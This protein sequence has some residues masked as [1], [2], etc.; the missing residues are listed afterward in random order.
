MMS[1]I[2][3]LSSIDL[4]SILRKFCAEKYQRNEKVCLSS[5]TTK[6]FS[7]MLC[8]FS[9]EHTILTLH[10]KSD[11]NDSRADFFVKN[12]VKSLKE[13]AKESRFF[14]K[15]FGV[16]SE[17]L[18]KLKPLVTIKW[19]PNCYL[20]KENVLV[21]ENLQDAG[22]EM[23]TNNNGL[24][25]VHHHLVAVSLL[26]AMHASSIV[27]E[28]E[29]NKIESEEW[30]HFLDENSYPSDPNAV[31]NMTLK[32]TVETL[33]E[34]LTRLPKYKDKCKEILPK[35]RKL[36]HQITDFVRPSQHYRNVFCHGDLWA[37][38]ILFKYATFSNGIDMND[39][40]PVAAVFVDFQLS[41]YAPPALDLMTM[42]TIPST[43]DF[44][45]QYLTRLCDAYYS[46]L[47]FEL[48]NHSI[49]IEC[50]YPREQFDES[51]KFY[52]VAGLIES[53]LF[54]H[55]TLLPNHLLSE[56]TNDPEKRNN[57]TTKSKTDICVEA[58]NTEEDYRNRMSDMLMELVDEYVEPETL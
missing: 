6:P 48:K 10:F 23:V 47:A 30:F 39:R 16:F 56:A 35:F 55:M 9:A 1:D 53:C 21:L 49:E 19:A 37:N 20:C 2:I 24:L 8:G 32:N 33:A 41:R 42:L 44:R 52:R 50:E 51:C 25:N 36:M 27:Y 11:E 26:A 58:F 54:S 45:H 38:N 4:I 14:E 40:I 43:R 31:R 57:F 12:S 34:L 18:P 3:E 7:E 5:Y 22:F 13:Y 46:H 17:I 29:N 15:E 28:K